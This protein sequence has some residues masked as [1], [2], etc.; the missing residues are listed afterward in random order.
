MRGPHRAV[1]AKRPRTRTVRG[2]MSVDP[3][4]RATRPDGYKPRLFICLA[5]EKTCQLRTTPTVSICSEHSSM[6]SGRV[7]D[8]ATAPFCWSGFIIGCRAPNVNGGG[9]CD[10][11]AAEPP[12]VLP[13]FLLSAIPPCDKMIAI[14]IEQEGLL[15]RKQR[16]FSHTRSRKA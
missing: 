8:I 15:W 14:K 12:P 9:S 5:G 4:R 2:C 3:L 11:C 7:I 13:R 10:R 16:G 6:Q 1:D